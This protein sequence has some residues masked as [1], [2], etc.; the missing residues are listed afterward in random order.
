M[1]L[2][3]FYGLFKSSES[4]PNISQGLI[5]GTLIYLIGLYSIH[6]QE[7]TIALIGVSILFFPLIGLAELFRNKK[8]P[9]QNMGITLIGIFYIIVPFLLI[10]LMRLNS[11]NYWPV[12]SIF[13]KSSSCDSLHETAASTLPSGLFFT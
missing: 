13:I 9:F 11:D 6:Q 3:E 10:N 1:S 5:I 8:V 7:F 12:L 4:S 2:N